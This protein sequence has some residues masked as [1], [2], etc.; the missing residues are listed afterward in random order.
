MTDRVRIEYLGHGPELER[1]RAS[2]RVQSVERAV[3]RVDGDT[4]ERV[5][6]P[7]AGEQNTYLVLYPNATGEEKSAVYEAMQSG[8]GACELNNF[9]SP[10]ALIEFA[11]PAGACVSLKGCRLQAAGKRFVI[12]GVSGLNS[13]RFPLVEWRAAYAKVSPAAS[14]V[15]SPAVASPVESPVAESLSC[16]ALADG[17]RKSTLSLMARMLRRTHPRLRVRVSANG[18]RLLVPRDVST[19]ELQ[20]VL[21]SVCRAMERAVS[22]SLRK[23]KMSCV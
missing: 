5:F 14:S 18:R 16:Y 1:A 23:E 10:A 22:E 21:T 12:A 13:R 6:G 8:D 2:P 3:W 11:R 9:V 4:M 7:R 20:S 15:A 19:Q 17:H